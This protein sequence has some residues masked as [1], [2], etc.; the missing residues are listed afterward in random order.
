MALVLSRKAGES[1]KIGDDVTVTVVEVRGGQVRVAVD[2][3]RDVSV[4]REEIYDQIN[5]QHAE[6]ENG[7]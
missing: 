5:Q 3:P 2:A 4:H 1:L 6:K 7:A